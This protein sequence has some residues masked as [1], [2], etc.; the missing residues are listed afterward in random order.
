[1]RKVRTPN[2]K[3]LKIRNKLIRPSRIKGRDILEEKCITTISCFVSF[4][5]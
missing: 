4:K 1:M 2:A 3:K 5:R